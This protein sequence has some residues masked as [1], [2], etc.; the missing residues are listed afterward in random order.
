MT[1]PD[2]QTRPGDADEPAIDPERARLARE[3]GMTYLYIPR[4]LDV[5]G[6]PELSVFSV[7]VLLVSVRIVGGRPQTGEALYEPDLST[8]SARG[9]RSWLSYRNVYGSRASMRITFDAASH[10]WHG[11]RFIDGRVVDEATGGSWQSFFLNFT[12]LGLLHGEPCRCH[13]EG[14]TR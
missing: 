12:A 1:T 5:V 10:T 11:A 9:I 14:V 4:R 2:S 7:N 3:R 8:F 6:R 13:G